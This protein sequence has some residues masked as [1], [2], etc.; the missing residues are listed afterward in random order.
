MLVSHA[1]R[2]APMAR[3]RQVARVS[4][5]LPGQHHSRFDEGLRLQAV[6]LVRL[7]IRTTV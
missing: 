7:S 5:P 6:E 1:R 4:R 3:V 2:T